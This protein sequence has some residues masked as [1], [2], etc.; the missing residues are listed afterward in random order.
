M[1]ERM[2]MKMDSIQNE[3]ANMKHE[4]HQLKQKLEQQDEEIE[5]IVRELRSFKSTQDNKEDLPES[6]SEVHAYA[7]ALL[8]THINK[9]KEDKANCSPVFKMS[10]LAKLYSSFMKDMG[11]DHIAHLSRSFP[12]Q[13]PLEHLFEAFCDILEGSLNNF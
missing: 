11:V 9:V 12:A 1:N 7:L 3:I 6:L 4:N 5:K 13:R 2:E 10:Y 8:I